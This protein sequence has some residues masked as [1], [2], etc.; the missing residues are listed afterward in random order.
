MWRSV[1]P[2]DCVLNSCDSLN[3]S[4]VEAAVAVQ[5][6][7]TAADVGLFSSPCHHCVIPVTKNII[8]AACAGYEAVSSIDPC[9]GIQINKMY[10]VSDHTRLHKLFTC[11]STRPQSLEC[12]G[13]SV[14]VAPSTCG[15]T[16]SVTERAHSGTCCSWTA[17]APAAWPWPTSSPSYRNMTHMLESACL[18]EL[19]TKT[20]NQIFIITPNVF[21]RDFNVT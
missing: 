8:A 7:V 14:H 12:V 1:F 3:P 11:N 10:S 16:P 21:H 4:D 6:P 19:S 5:R 13:A 20:H 18:W 15:R 17:E 9:A 2:C